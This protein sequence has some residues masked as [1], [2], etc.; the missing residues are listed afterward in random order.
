MSTT[1]L[2]VIPARGGSK[3]LRRKNVLPLAGR[4]MLSYTIRCAI[5]SGI[6]D[7]IIVVSDSD[8]ILTV[9]MAEDAG[10]MREP[11]EMAGDHVSSTVPVLWVEEQ[12]EQTFDYVWN[13]QPTSPLR[14]PDDI[15]AAADVLAA[16]PEADFLASVTPI[17]PHYFHWAL[18][19]DDEGFSALWFPDFLV[20]RSL[21]PPVDR[22][23]G[24]IKVGRPAR[25]REAGS[26]FNPGLVTVE[27]E[28][29]RSIHVRSS[30]DM[31]LAEF[32]VQKYEHDFAWM[33]R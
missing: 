25:L 14:V 2:A 28:D 27:I 26:V 32:V 13:L 4:P 22:P 24:A 6:F 9:G 15:R 10:A 33:R 5:K 20:D 11:D 8:E 17:D 3:G 31:E 23:N 21:L 16:T 12:L 1:H 7:E 29:H 19:T 18:K 30:W